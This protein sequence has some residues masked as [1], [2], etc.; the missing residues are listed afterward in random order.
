M[1]FHRDDPGHERIAT[2]DIETTHFEATGGELV[3]IGIGVHDRGEP[4]KSATYDTFYRDGRG[5]AE[6]VRQ[7]VEQLRGY[8]ADG[9]VSYNGI[10]FDLPFVADRLELLGE[11][12]AL[13]EIATSRDRHLDLFIDRKEYATQ[14]NI[15]WP[16]L[17]QCLEAYGL[18]LPRT[19]WGGREV[20]NTRFGEELGP[21]YLQAVSDD[22]EAASQLVEVIDHYLVTDLEANIALFHADVGEEFEH[23]FIGSVREF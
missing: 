23:E 3:S 20:T 4:G 12:V 14:R 5:E 18:P 13:P 1:Q 8:D 22:R 15:K 19:V 6:L 2:F 21:A 17:E 9:L 16:S 10:Q 7:A 11:T